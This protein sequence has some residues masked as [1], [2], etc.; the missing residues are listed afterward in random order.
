MKQSWWQMAL[1]SVLG[2]SGA[3]ASQGKTSTISEALHTGR[4]RLTSHNLGAGIAWETQL[5]RHP[6]SSEALDYSGAFEPS[7]SSTLRSLALA[8]VP[9]TALLFSATSEAA[10]PAG[11]AALNSAH[12]NFCAE[13]EAKAHVRSFEAAPACEDR[14][15]RVCSAS[16]IETACYSGKVNGSGLGWEWSLS[17][18]QYLSASANGS[19]DA[20]AYGELTDRASL[21]CC[22]SQ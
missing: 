15:A 3:G 21:R 12:G 19:C 9:L 2:I 16:E 6:S 5:L 20:L 10:C 7:R 17:L 14:S 13:I 8:L 22:L 18:G 4:A 11:F 1:F